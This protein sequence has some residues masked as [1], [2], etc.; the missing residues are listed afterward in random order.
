MVFI[1]DFDGTLTP[2][3]LPNYEILAKCGYDGNSIMV[4]VKRIINEQ[5][6]DLYT[7]YCIAFREVFEK[8]EIVFNK[9]NLCLGVND[10]KFNKG[11]LEYFNKLC[12]VNSGIKHYV[13]TSG[14]EDFIRE[15]KVYKCLYG[16]LGTCFYTTEDGKYGDIKRL[17]R[18]DRKVEAIEEIRSEN[19]VELSDIIYFGDGLTDIDA[20]RYVHENGGKSIL[21]CSGAKD[22]EV[23]QSLNSLG[24][25]DECFEL[26]YSVDSLLY[27]YVNNLT[28]DYEGTYGKR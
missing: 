6:V 23:Y 4:E 3:A 11:V 7:A 14:F 10:L 20:F 21:V 8:N 9:D 24:I 27:H 2:Y 17:M 28:K 22:N 1:Y 19:N 26:D 15:T 25:I 12:Y 18:N 16:V 13:V 5:N